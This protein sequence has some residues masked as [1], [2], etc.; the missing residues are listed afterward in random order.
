MKLTV[1]RWGHA[2]RMAVTRI[3]YKILVLKI[4]RE[5]TD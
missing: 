3:A 2:A 4:S 5:E 1:M